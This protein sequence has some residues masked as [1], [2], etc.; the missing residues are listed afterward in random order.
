MKNTT[1]WQ[2]DEANFFAICLLM[3]RHFFVDAIKRLE[4][5]MAD[6]TYLENISRLA[7]AFQ[8]P[9]DSVSARIESLGGLRKIL[10]K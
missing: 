3:P 6:N 2:E 1:K 4:W 5:S 7:D 9:T 8:V 10:S